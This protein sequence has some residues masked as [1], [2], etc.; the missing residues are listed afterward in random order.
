[1]GFKAAVNRRFFICIFLHFLRDFLHL[2]ERDRSPGL[3]ATRPRSKSQ[4]PLKLPF[5]S[6]GPSLLLR[7]SVDDDVSG[8]EMLVERRPQR[9]WHGIDFAVFAL[10]E[11]ALNECR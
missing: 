2:S 6:K 1:M 5:L 11:E 3:V 8:I 9:L 10:I 4:D 7:L